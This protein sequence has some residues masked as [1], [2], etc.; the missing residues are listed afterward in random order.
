M[1]DLDAEM[2]K[3]PLIASH[4][5]HVCPAAKPSSATQDQQYTTGT[6]KKTTKTFQV[7]LL[8]PEISQHSKS[9]RKRTLE[10]VAPPSLSLG[11]IFV[12]CLREIS[13]HLPPA[14]LRSK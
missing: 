9:L 4:A 6:I 12:G 14:R 7:L 1:A 3:E 5:G 13:R 2:L 8:R 11:G 10:L